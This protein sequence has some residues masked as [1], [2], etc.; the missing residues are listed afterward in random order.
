MQLNLDDAENQERG[1]ESQLSDL[2]VRLNK[3]LENLENHRQ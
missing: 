1:I 3:E 2:Q